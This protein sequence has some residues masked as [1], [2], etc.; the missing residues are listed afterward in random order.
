MDQRGGT[1]ALFLK[2]EQPAKISIGRLGTFSFPAGY[3]VYVGSALGSGGLK[4]RL[5]RHQ[6]GDKKLHWHIDYFLA[7]ACIV[8]IHTNGSGKRLECKWA[9]AL[10]S[11]PEAQ[12]IAPRLGASDCD[13]PTHLIYIGKDS[14]LSLAFSTK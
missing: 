6:R 3:Y 8:G 9:Q 5:A 2:M 1:Y 13:C 14:A 4:A 12:V 7:H 11:V 10:L